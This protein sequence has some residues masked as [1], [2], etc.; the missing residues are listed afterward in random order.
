MKKAQ[1]GFTLIELMIV[2]AIIGI[3]AAIAIPA[4]QD[5][6]IRTRVG[7]AVNLASGSK[8]AVAEFFNARSTW[9]ADNDEA[10]IATA[11]SITGEFVTSVTVSGGVITAVLNSANT[12]TA[13]NFVLSPIDNVGSV[14]W[15]CANNSTIATKYLPANCR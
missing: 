6:T 9:P 5:Y 14:D 1:S 10:G 7:E 15:D 8:T 13:G 3:L 4:Y 12:G 11:A 2:I